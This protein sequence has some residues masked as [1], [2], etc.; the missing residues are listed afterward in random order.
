MILKC[1]S[2]KMRLNLSEFW[3]ANFVTAAS[4][5]QVIPPFWRSHFLS[6]DCHLIT[7]PGRLCHM[8]SS[9][10]TEAQQV[11]VQDIH[12]LCSMQE[13]KHTHQLWTFTFY[14]LMQEYNTPV[15]YRLKYLNAQGFFSNT[16]ANNSITW[17]VPETCPEQLI[18][19]DFSISPGVCQNNIFPWG[20]TRGQQRHKHVSFWLHSGKYSSFDIS[21]RAGCPS[22]EGEIR[23]EQLRNEW[24]Y[25]NDKGVFGKG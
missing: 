12:S 19:S 13:H 9:Y 24:N 2:C 16:T 5:T 14:F 6:H 8:G 25:F 17:N 15:Q 1:W 18:R 11:W 10:E 23:K 4:C 22:E 3:R 21:N 20:N 7:A